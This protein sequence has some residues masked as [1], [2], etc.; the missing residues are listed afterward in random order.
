M[1][2]KHRSAVARAARSAWLESGGADEEFRSLCAGAAADIDADD[3]ENAA[4]IARE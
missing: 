4:A 1:T 3:G 2:P